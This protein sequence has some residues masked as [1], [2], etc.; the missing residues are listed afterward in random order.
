[1]VLID[2]LLSMQKKLFLINMNPS[3]S[4]VVQQRNYGFVL[5]WLVNVIEIE[6]IMA[7]LYRDFFTKSGLI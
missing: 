6:S 7:L 2:L 5:L 1:M 3:E 4:L